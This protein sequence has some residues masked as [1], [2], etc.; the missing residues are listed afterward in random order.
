MCGGIGH[1]AGIQ[2][3]GGVQ[4]EEPPYHMQKPP[5]TYRCTWEHW[6]HMGDI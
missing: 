4:T 1:M 6:G 3:H 2:T 5:R